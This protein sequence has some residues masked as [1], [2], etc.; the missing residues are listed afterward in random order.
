M[1]PH[2]LDERL[3]VLLANFPP[4]NLP[5]RE[6]QGVIPLSLNNAFHIVEVGVK[7]LVLKMQP[8]PGRKSTVVDASGDRIL[9]LLAADRLFAALF[10]LRGGVKSRLSS[11]AP[12]ED[13]AVAPTLQFS[14]TP[15]A[16]M[17]SFDR[18][19]SQSFMVTPSL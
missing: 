2:E 6:H 19:P 5:F 15:S 18:V 13:G 17:A 14:V 7:P 11:R 4:K 9:D 3:P 1:I 8:R 16:G 12:R 10:H